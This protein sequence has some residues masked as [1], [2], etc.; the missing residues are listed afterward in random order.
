MQSII[1]KALLLTGLWT[2]FIYLF[3]IIEEIEKAAAFIFLMISR[4]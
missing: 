2:K 4:I 1:I 3:E